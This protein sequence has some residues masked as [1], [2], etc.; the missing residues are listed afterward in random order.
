MAMTRAQLLIDSLTLLSSPADA[1]LQYLRHLG[2]RIGVDELA[3]E[4]DDIAAAAEDM[5]Q[6]S[7]LT[8]AQCDAAQRLRKYLMSISGASNWSLWTPE[9]LYSASE[10]AE[11]RRMASEALLLLSNSPRD[12]N[13]G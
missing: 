10:W 12:A 9:A 5:R 6:S 4:Y 13:G 2:D 7:E 1:Q 8:A 3:L 11:V